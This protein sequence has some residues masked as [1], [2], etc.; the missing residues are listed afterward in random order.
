MGQWIRGVAILGLFVWPPLLY[1]DE[2]P[3][4]LDHWVRPLGSEQ[5]VH[6]CEAYAGKVLLVVNTASK[7]G[8]TYQYAGLEHLAERYRERGLVVLGFP[9]NDFGEQE[10]GSEAEIQRFCRDTY[11]V[12]FPMFEKVRAAAGAAHPFYQGLAAARGRYPSWNFH[13]YLIDRQGR[14]AD[15]WRSRTEPESASVIQAIEKLL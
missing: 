7:C 11:S 4:L 9:S 3:A 10:P 14:V 15:D 5:P 1:A 6:L 8:Y 13:K 2:C 12:R